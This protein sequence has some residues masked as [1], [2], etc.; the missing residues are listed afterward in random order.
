MP[1]NLTLQDVRKY[2]IDFTAFQIE[3]LLQFLQGPFEIGMIS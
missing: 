3:L 2:N 1:N